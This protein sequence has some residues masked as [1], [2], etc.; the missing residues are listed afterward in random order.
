MIKVL[1]E[2]E[3][4]IAVNKPHGLLSHPSNECRQVK[5]NLLFDV[6]D[7]LGMHVHPVNRLDRGTSGIMLL[8]KSR[9]AVPEMQKIWATD[10]IK[11]K[12]LALCHDAIEDPGQFDFE[13]G[14][15]NKVKQEALTLY[16]PLEVFT[17]STLMDIEI[18]TGRRHQIRRHFSRRMHALLGDRKYGKKKWND[19]YLEKYQLK[20][21][22]LHSYILEFEHPYTGEEIKLYCPLDED[23]TGPLEHIRSAN[24]RCL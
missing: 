24:K 1:F 12:Y 6:R 11:K 9:E 22:F 4:Y 20:R 3:Y 17:D 13:L 18:K 5:E 8:A 2:D 10:K 15:D 21:I 23:L 7:H 19:E 16:T 14:N